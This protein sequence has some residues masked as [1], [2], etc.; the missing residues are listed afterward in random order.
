[1]II[2]PFPPLCSDNVRFFC[3]ITLRFDKISDD[4]WYG[5]NGII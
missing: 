5:N 3:V 1:M 2:F 4:L